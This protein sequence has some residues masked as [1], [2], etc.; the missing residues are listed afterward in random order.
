MPQMLQ[1]RLWHT[2]SRR[3][4]QQDLGTCQSAT[5]RTELIAA[6]L[7]GEALRHDEGHGPAAR[8]AV[9]KARQLPPVALCQDLP[10]RVHQLHKHMLPVNRSSLHPPCALEVCMSLHPRLALGHDPL[11]EQSCFY[12]IHSQ[13]CWDIVALRA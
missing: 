7:E 2:W 12:P 8:R 13:G 11:M 4:L 6:H 10:H 1:H 5:L 3:A 9:Y